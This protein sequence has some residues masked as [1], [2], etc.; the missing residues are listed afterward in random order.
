MAERRMFAKTI[1]DSDAFLEMPA[2]TQ[3]LY[4]H[5][6]MRADDEGFINNPKR[7]QKMVGASD[8]DLK[9]LL[10]K[11]F[12][13]GFE[14]GIIVIKHWKIHNYIRADRLAGTKYQEERMML[15]IKE[16]GAYTFK[17]DFLELDDD[18][19][20]IDMSVKCQPNVSIGKDRLGKDSIGKVNNNKPS[21]KAKHKYGEYKNV[22]LTDEERERLD[23]DYGY[24]ANAYI[25]FLDEYI[26][27]KGYKSNSHNLSI[28]R[29]V[30]DAVD[31]K[32]SSTPVT[33][34]NEPR[35]PEEYQTYNPNKYES[36]NNR[37]MSDEFI[38]E[39]LG[40]SNG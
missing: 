22:L 17:D 37:Q 13:L 19:K 29:W 40:E 8:D 1:I 10:A 39:L 34:R 30:V 5:L 11:N 20:S 26:E 32:K 35:E 9:I 6:S 24:A 21:K 31:K 12:V 16:N 38:N 28:R 18:L 4:F 14:S 15:D 25:D 33:Y 3:M 7:I 23:K 27:E 36:S 2:T